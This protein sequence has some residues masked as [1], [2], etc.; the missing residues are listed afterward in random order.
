MASNLA[1][2]YKKIDVAEFSALNTSFHDIICDAAQSSYLSKIL[3]IVRL[4]I[5]RFRPYSLVDKDHRIRG[6]EEH[7]RMIELLRS[8][9]KVNLSKLVAK[10]VGDVGDAVAKTFGVKKKSEE[11]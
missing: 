4:P 8:R 3:E 5:L 6:V 9:D 11:E 10:H 2:R 7:N 1:Q